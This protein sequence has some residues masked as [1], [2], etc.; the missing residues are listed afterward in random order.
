MLSVFI[1]VR[2]YEDVACSAITTANGTNKEYALH[3]LHQY[4]GNVRVSS[5]DEITLINDS[6]EFI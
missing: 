3:I 2:T 4:G 6:V 1:A 5:H